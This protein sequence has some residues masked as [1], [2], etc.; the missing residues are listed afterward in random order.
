MEYWLTYNKVRS[1]YNCK[2][3]REYHSE[4][5]GNFLKTIPMQALNNGRM[6][7][8]SVWFIR[9]FIFFLFLI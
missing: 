4:K 7:P 2:K 3:L 1:E 9:V 5:E 8:R 6:K